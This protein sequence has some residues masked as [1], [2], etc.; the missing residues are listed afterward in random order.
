[1]SMSARMATSTKRTL[2]AAAGRSARTAAGT[3]LMFHL[4]LHTHP[5]R[6]RQRRGQQPHKRP[7]ALHSPP[8]ALLNLLPGQRNR[9]PVPRHSLPP[10]QRR[11]QLPDLVQA[12]AAAAAT[13]APSPPLPSSIVTLTHARVPAASPGRV[14][15]LR[16]HVPPAPPARAVVVKS[17]FGPF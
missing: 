1:M 10:V 9:P 17:R 8:R 4:Q 11:S 3:T 12:A 5:E 15:V 14:P 2:M 16:V 7:R 13:R 6:P